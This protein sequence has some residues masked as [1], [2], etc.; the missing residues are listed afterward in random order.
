MKDR[1]EAI[2][3]QERKIRE[4][5]KERDDKFLEI[6]DNLSYSSTESFYSWVKNYINPK[7]TAAKAEIRRLKS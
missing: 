2:A 1:K 6:K 7:I 3:E 5:E 4:A